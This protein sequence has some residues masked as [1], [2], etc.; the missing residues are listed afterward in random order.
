MPVADADLAHAEVVIRGTLANSVAGVKNFANVFHYR[1]NAFAIPASKASLRT[2]FD[3]NIAQVYLAAAADAVA[4]MAIGVRWVSDPSDVE[5]IAVGNPLTAGQIATDS[6][7][8]QNAV[9]MLLRTAMRGRSRRGAKRWAGVP[10]AD[11]TR[12]VLA[13][14]GLARWQALQTALALPLTDA[15]GNVWSLEIISRKLSVLTTSPATV[16]AAD[17]ASVLLNKNIGSQD[18]RRPPTVR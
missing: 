5:S 11:A 4:N 3:A 17:V 2:I 6:M 7:P 8:N 13:G 10:E 18:S 1:R 15:D 14:A 9:S 12:D 16:D